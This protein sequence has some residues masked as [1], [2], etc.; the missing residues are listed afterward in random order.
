MKKIFLLTLIAIP[1]FFLV[2]EIYAINY[3]W[4]NQT[5]WVFTDMISNTGFYLGLWQGA[6]DWIWSNGK[7][8]MFYA[9]TT[10]TGITAY[11]SLSC[12]WIKAWSPTW[13]YYY[14]SSTNPRLGLSHSWWKI[15][16][17]V[18]ADDNISKI[19]SGVVLATLTVWTWVTSTDNHPNE[20]VMCAVISYVLKTWS[21]FGNGRYLYSISTFHYI[22]NTTIYNR[23]N[24]Y[25]VSENDPDYGL[26]Y[27]TFSNL[28]NPFYLNTSSVRYDFYFESSTISEPFWYTPDRN[29]YRLQIL[30]DF[31]GVTN[32]WKL[33]MTLPNYY[34]SLNFTGSVIVWPNVPSSSWSTWPDFSSCGTIEI[35][36]YIST[37]FSWITSYIPDL[38]FSEWFNSCSTGS[39]LTWWTISEKLS[40]LVSI[41]NP[42]PPNEGTLICWL[43][44]SWILDYSQASQSGNVFTV[45]A[46][47]QV[48][49]VLESDWIV[50]YGQNLLDIVVIIWVFILIFRPRK[51]V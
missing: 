11:K 24:F 28:M 46:H 50:A 26:R 33:Q 31:L 47:W 41:I 30:G 43:F 32:S 13:D 10:N 9:D 3:V 37:F 1:L 22:S 35:G 36:C 34:K 51:N 19:L 49:E 4:S 20:N 7:Y 8:S 12:F 27:S 2:E 6:W 38:S 40:R 15:F 45:Y 18:Y 29:S 17:N 39:S 44:W 25:D 5:S 21:F 48:P 42:I 16:L 14:D 23:Y